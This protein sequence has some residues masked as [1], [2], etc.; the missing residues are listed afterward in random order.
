MEQT[1]LTRY[2]T[3]AA[4]MLLICR[5]HAGRTETLLQRRQNTGYADGLWDV[6]ASGHLEAAEP[7]SAA[8][9][10][11]AWE[12]TRLLIRPADL[13]FQTLVHKYAADIALPYFNIYFRAERW[14][15]E[16][17]IGEPEKCSELAWFPLDALPA[18]LIAD[19]RAVL[20][21]LRD[22]QPEPYRELGW[23]SQ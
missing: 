12:E 18:D 17:T 22:A 7:L 9:C 6:A 23:P 4:V 5:E 13:R 14:Q 1:P 2:T 20:L 3:R 16:P 21:A 15:G 8:V 19:R 10:R 11:E